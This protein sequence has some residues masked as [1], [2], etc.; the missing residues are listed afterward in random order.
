MFWD[1]SK[2]ETTH[3]DYIFESS[4]LIKKFEQCKDTSTRWADGMIFLLFLPEMYLERGNSKAILK[5]FRGAL[6][7]FDRAIELL[8]RGRA[9]LLRGA[10]KGNLGMREEAC[11]DLSIAG[12]KG[13]KEAY[14]MIQ[15]FC[16]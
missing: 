16:Q 1:L 5:D 13:E 4:K 15:K 10:V 12:E 14:K 11:L 7:D 9:Y 8:P 3:S 6:L 2:K